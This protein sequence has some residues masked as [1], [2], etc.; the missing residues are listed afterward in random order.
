VGVHSVDAD[1]AFRKLPLERV[2]KTDDRGRFSIRGLQPG[3]YRVFALADIN[4][5]FKWDNPAEDIA[6]MNYT[7]SPTAENITVS[8]T[9][10]NMQTAEVDSVVM[11]PG[12]RYLPN[13]LL[14]S[15]F[16]VDYKPQYLA[17]SERPDS[18]RL[19]FAFNAPFDSLPSL[20]MLNTGGDIPAI[21]ER[22]A[23]NDT[24]TYWLTD[25]QDIKSDTIRVVARYMRNKEL[26][27]WEE[28]IDTLTL[29]N[30]VKKNN[31]KKPDSKK[32]DDKESAP[33][34]PMLTLKSDGGNSQ[35]VYK[36]RPIEFAEPLKEMPVRWKLEVK[37]DTVWMSVPDKPALR[38]DTLNPRLYFVD[39]PWEY[40]TGYRVTID[41]IAAVG[42]SGLHNAPFTTEFITRK[43][44]DYGALSFTLSNYNDSIPAFVEL[45]NSSDKVVRTAKV[46]NHTVVFKYLQ[47]TK[48][49]A[50][51][52]EDVNGNGIYDTGDYD[53]S[54]QPEAV[55]YYPKKINLKKNWDMNLSWDVNALPVDLQKPSAVKKNKPT[56][57][58][59]KKQDAEQTDE[60]DE[61]ETFDPT[62]NPF[63]PNQK[64]KR[65]SSITSAY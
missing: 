40:E 31:P 47:P 13:D 51:F 12:V 61:D 8:D 49:F 9:I 28:A 24:L 43:E 17:S 2:A 23:A 38:Q 45:L 58:K 54:L 16:N 44:S 52:V 7:V 36:P 15:V 60:E 6:F 65:S 33:A 48:Y 62:A 4:N 41:S 18:G 22:T 64:K 20:K 57:N 63:D 10:Y 30:K 25:S 19:V 37:S 46:E 1:T 5:D 59:R 50:R 55:S 56:S 11:R 32:K 26:G 53:T 21:L 35:E 29:V 27:V 39:Y 34:V 42:I 3:T 14:L